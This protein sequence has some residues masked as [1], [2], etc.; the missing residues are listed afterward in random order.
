MAIDRIKTCEFSKDFI[1][2]GKTSKIYAVTTEDGKTGQAWEELKEGQ[3]V[4]IQ[5]KEWN[6]KKTYTFYPIKEKAG[7]KG[8]PQKDWQYEKRRSSLECAVELGKASG[9]KATDVIKVAETF[10]TYLN[11]K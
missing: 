4:N 5:E 2:D 3:E 10:F 7:G 9:A 6:G 1:K 8:F 11:Q